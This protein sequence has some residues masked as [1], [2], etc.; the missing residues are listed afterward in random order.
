M[1]S[2]IRLYAHIYRAKPD[3]VRRTAELRAAAMA[4]SDAWVAAGCHLDGPALAQ[5]RLAP[6]ASFTALRRPATGVVWPA[7]LG[8]ASNRCPQI[9]LREVTR[10]R[11]NR[12]AW[13]P[14]T[15]QEILHVPN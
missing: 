9:C 2:L 3:D 6:V 14:R 4:L 13:W 8:K 12:S 1:A 5:Q 11:L 15:S 7:I 10:G